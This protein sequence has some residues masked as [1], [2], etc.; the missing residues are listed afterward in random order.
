MD[1]QFFI[2]SAQAMERSMYCIAR[3]YLTARGQLRGRAAKRAAARLG[4]ANSPRGAVFPH[5]A[6]AHI[7]RRLKETLRRQ[8]PKTAAADFPEAAAPQTTR[9]VGIAARWIGGAHDVIL[10]YRDRLGVREIASILRIP[11]STV[12][13]RLSR[14]RQQLK[15]VLSRGVVCMN[16]NQSNIDRALGDTPAS[17]SACMQSTLNHCVET[18]RAPRRLTARA[19]PG[20][21]AG[22]VCGAAVAMVSAHGLDRWM[23]NRWLYIQEF[24]ADLYARS[25]PRCQKQME[26]TDDQPKN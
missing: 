4:K 18:R 14:A 3:W 11:E 2:A 25:K 5:L 9:A 19:D 26:Q 6:Y 24:N 22:A 21:C 1:R 7:D 10:H 23:N 17:F 13:T 15:S 20:R 16:L 8:K 12:K